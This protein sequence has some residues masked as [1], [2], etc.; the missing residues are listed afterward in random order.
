MIKTLKI[1]N[2]YSP[3]YIGV[4]F[5]FGL[6]SLVHFS[7]K[8]KV[9]SGRIINMNGR[10]TRNI[11]LFQFIDSNLTYVLIYG[12]VVFLVILFAQYR[13]F[14]RSVTFISVGI[15]LIPCLMY[16]YVCAYL[17]GKFII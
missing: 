16:F 6:I 2:K 13:K 3:P 8:M 14:S 12:L 9:E 5:L 15:I 7:S 10:T 17:S 1:I 11:E 4:L